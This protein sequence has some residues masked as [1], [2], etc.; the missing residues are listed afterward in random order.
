MPQRLPDGLRGGPAVLVRL[1]V[2]V[3]QQSAV[4]VLVADRSHGVR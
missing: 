2:E 3:D 1:G 4:A